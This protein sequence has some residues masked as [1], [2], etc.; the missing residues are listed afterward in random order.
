MG[1]GHDNNLRTRKLLQHPT[2]SLGIKEHGV[3]K[4]YELS[5]LP[6][7]LNISRLAVILCA[8]SSALSK[9]NMMSLSSLGSEMAQTPTSLHAD[10][11]N[12][13]PEQISPHF[14]WPYAYHRFTAWPWSKYLI[15][16][17]HRIVP[18]HC[19]DGKFLRF[20]FD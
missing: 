7:Y 5:G 18:T 15:L 6:L 16:S 11:T 17:H 14:I 1:L 10:L 19:S 12:L 20:S 4:S 2:E 8:I 9:E 3:Y 13:L